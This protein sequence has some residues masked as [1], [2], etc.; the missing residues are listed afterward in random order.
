MG[1]KRKSF[2]SRLGAHEFPEEL[3]VQRPTRLNRGRDGAGSASGNTR[4]GSWSLPEDLCFLAVLRAMM[5]ANNSDHDSIS[6]A[7]WEIL[8]SQYNE[9]TP[10]DKVDKHQLYCRLKT[11]K[12]SY[13]LNC[14]L[15][16]K[17]GWTWDDTKQMAVAPNDNAWE[18]LIEVRSYTSFINS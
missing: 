18:E 17:R 2:P 8:L 1:G 15:R 16:S 3:H 7:Q 10:G 13:N 14:A 9:R 4:R 5:L 6:R 12:Q 11:L